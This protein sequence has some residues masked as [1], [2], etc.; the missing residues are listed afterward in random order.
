MGRGETKRNEGKQGG[1]GD[2]G[3]ERGEVTKK[4]EREG[5]GKEGERCPITSPFC[6]PQYLSFSLL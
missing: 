4:S 1:E 3:G 6:F 2:K 5:E